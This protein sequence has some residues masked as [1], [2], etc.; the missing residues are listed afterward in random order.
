MQVTEEEA[1]QAGELSGKYQWTDEELALMVKA[2]KLII[3]Y[4][5]GKGPE[6]Q[7]ALTPL[8][9]ELRMYEGFVTTRKRFK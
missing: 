6:W 4:L 5:K 2:N 1:K 8:R 9:E 7:L 3:A